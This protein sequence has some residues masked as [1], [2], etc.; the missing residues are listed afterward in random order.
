[1]D[2]QTLFRDGVTAIKE[3]RD[4]AEARK[5][6]T[7]SLRLDPNNEMAWVWLSRTVTDNEK[8]IQC[9]DRALTINPD[10]EQALQLKERLLAT[11]GDGPAAFVDVPND[12]IAA[13]KAPKKPSG[14]DQ[15]RIQ[16]MLD[17]AEALIA[18]GKT[19][20]AIEQWVR[21]LEIQVDHEQAIANAVRYL[22]RLKYVDDA[23]ELVWR[24]IESGTKVTSIYLTGIDIAKHLRDDVKADELRDKLARLPSADD[25]MVSKIVDHYTE[26]EQIARAIEILE[27]AL[28][29]HTKSQKLLIRMGDLQKASSND[30][31]ARRYYERAA[32]L[33]TRSKE[34]K[35]ADKKLMESAPLLT[36]HER[37]SMMLAVREAFGFGVVYLMMGVQD[38]GM[39]LATMGSSRWLGVAVSIVGGYLLDTA[40]WSP[41]QNPLAGWLGGQMPEKKKHDEKPK[42]DA[43]NTKAQH[44]PLEDDTQLPIIPVGVRIV[45]GLLGAA[46]LVFAFTLVFDRALDLLANPVPMQDVP[47][48]L[49]LLEELE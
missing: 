17:Q 41:Q 46:I 15:L 37:G 23:K 22:S 2:A 6:L 27:H 43:L 4:I 47:S 20:D 12:S 44:G 11:N 30:A 19:E 25:E 26:R 21:V 36:D 48:L 34:G 3:K 31:E 9:L 45:F 28:Q 29:T 38:A 5:L 40:L 39:S 49:D 18:E 8:K 35:D 1:M 32:R 33:G 14:A 42:P 7:Q 13:P 10:N 16:K 24:A